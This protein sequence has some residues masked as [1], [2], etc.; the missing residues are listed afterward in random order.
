MS[1][2]TITFVTGNKKKLEEVRA[3]FAGHPLADRLDNKKI[4]LPELQGEPDEIAAEKCRLAAAEVHH[5][6]CLLVTSHWRVLSGW[7]RSNR[8]GHMPVLQCD[9]GSPWSLHQVVPG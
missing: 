5:H 4:D 6:I 3:I 9:E 1:S 7:W 8:R 2:R